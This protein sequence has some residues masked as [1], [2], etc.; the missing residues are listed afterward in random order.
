MEQ[1]ENAAY[2]KKQLNSVNVKRWRPIVSVVYF[3]DFIVYHNTEN[4]IRQIKNILI[5]AD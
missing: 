3:D 1:Y 5:A 4:S 2:L